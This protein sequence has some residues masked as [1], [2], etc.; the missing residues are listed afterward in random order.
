MCQ[1]T[2]VCVLWCV[3]VVCESLNAIEHSVRFSVCMMCRDCQLQ[4]PLLRKPPSVGRA[5]NTIRKT[6]RRPGGG[7][8]TTPVRRTFST[9]KTHNYI[10]MNSLPGVRGSA[11]WLGAKGGGGGVCGPLRLA[12]RTAPS[13]RPSW[14]I[15]Q[16]PLSGEPSCRRISSPLAARP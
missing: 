3:R 1:N 2:G 12:E 13:S 10:M 15:R 4:L 9:S 7:R 8:A 11:L 16:S 6:N 14:E 5:W